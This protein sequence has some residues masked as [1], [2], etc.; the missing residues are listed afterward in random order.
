MSN[1]YNRK[2]RLKKERSNYYHFI[3]SSC[4]LELLRGKL[5]YQSFFPG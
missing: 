5:Y 3:Y 1:R 4:Y 2:K